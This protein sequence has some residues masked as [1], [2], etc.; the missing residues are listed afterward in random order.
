MRHQ[1]NGLAIVQAFFY[2]DNIFEACRI[3]I[4]ALVV[5]TGSILNLHRKPKPVA[6]VEDILP[7]PVVFYC[8]GTVWTLCN[9]Q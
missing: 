9:L 6:L 2:G 1:H 8:A 3:Y 5:N 7:H 4:A